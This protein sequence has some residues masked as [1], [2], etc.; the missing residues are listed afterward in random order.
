VGNFTND[1][2]AR[3]D[4]I[5]ESNPFDDVKVIADKVSEYIKLIRPE[6]FTP[7][8]ARGGLARILEM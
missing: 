8:F 1:E 7:S 3:I 2:F 5:I 4:Q 6:G